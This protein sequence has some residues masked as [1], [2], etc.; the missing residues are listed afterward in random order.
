M[1]ISDKELG[2]LRNLA[3]K[4]AGLDVDWINIAVAR[5][6]TELGFARRTRGGW[7][8]TAEGL[9][10][11]KGQAEPPRLVELGH[12]PSPRLVVDISGEND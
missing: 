5:T 9:A 7:E 12:L 3:D 11:I 1:A 4:H 10:V 8:I 2:A 6:L